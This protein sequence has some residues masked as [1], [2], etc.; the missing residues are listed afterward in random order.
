MQPRDRAIKKQRVRAVQFLQEESRALV[1][2]DRFLRNRE[3]NPAICGDSHRIPDIPVYRVFIEGRMHLA[4]SDQ[5]GA[6]LGDKNRFLQFAGHRGGLGNQGSSAMERKD[7]VGLQ[8]KIALATP[9]LWPPDRFPLH[10]T[11][12]NRRTVRLE[13]PGI[14]AHDQPPPLTCQPTLQSRKRPQRESIIPG[15]EKPQSLPGGVDQIASPASSA[16]NPC[17][18]PAHCLSSPQRFPPGGQNPQP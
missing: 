6:G 13:H 14:H 2:T 1:K 3:P 7:A 17:L 11:P 8:I 12:A 18:Q 9:Q 4:R 10:H 5:Q 15:P 16:V